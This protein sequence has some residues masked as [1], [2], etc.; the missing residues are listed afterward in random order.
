MIGSQV[1][2]EI[3]VRGTVQGVGFRP[4]VWRLARA[5]AV[6]GDVRNDAAGV[7]IN[8][9]GDPEDVKRFVALLLSDAPPLA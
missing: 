8:A 9:C 2:L 5:H 4:N 3:R 7:L 1:A 6:S